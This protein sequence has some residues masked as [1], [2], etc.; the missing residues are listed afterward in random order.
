M[1]YH[2][3]QE[4]QMMQQGIKNQGCQASAVPR[5]ILVSSVSDLEY[6]QLATSLL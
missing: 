3:W 4:K 5:H 2:W 6:A 1:N